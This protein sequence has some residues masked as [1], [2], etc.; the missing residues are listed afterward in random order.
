MPTTETASQK[1]G[2]GREEL[3]FQVIVLVLAAVAGLGCWF[4]ATALSHHDAL[5]GLA[6]DN[7]RQLADFALL[8]SAGQP[9]TREDLNGK[10]LAVSFLFTGCGVTCPEVSRHMAQIQQLTANQPDVRLVSLTVDPRSDTPPVLA[11]WG[12]QY[13]ADTNRWLMLTG[14]KAALEQLIGTS[15]LASS[16]GDPFNSMP[17]NFAGTERIAIVDKHGRIRLYFDGLRAETPAAV[18]AEIEKLRTEDQTRKE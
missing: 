17:G 10:V 5:R 4:A 1:T 6:P 11:K 13:G 18:A 14:P 8:N 16:P 9:V 2:Q 3:L 12:A 7:A 15:F